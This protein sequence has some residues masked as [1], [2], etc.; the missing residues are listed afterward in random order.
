[1]KNTVTVHYHSQSGHYFDYSFWSWGKFCVGEHSLFSA[2]DSFGLVGQITFESSYFLEYLYVVVKGRNQPL[3]IKPFK[4]QRHK[5]LETTEV[6]IV[7]GD[8][9]LYYS[10]QAAHTSRYYRYR[11]VHAFDMAVNAKRFDNKWGFDGWLG[12]KYHCNE[13]QFRL[14]A[15]TAKKVELLFYE[16]SANDAPL[17]DVIIMNRGQ[18]ENPDNHEENTHGVWFATFFGNYDGQAYTYRL[19]FEDRVVESRDPYSIATTGNGKRSVILSSEKRTPSGFCVKHGKDATWRLDNPNQSV[20]AEMHIRD[21]S[22]SKTSGVSLANRGTYLGACEVETVNDFG[23]KTCFDYLKELEVSHVQ[24]QPIF[25]HHQVIDADGNFAYNWGYDPENYNVPEASFSSQPDKPEVR[26]LELKTMIQ[27]YHNAGIGVIMDVVYNHTY[28]SYDSLFQRI[29]PDYYH[30]MN[31][32]GSFQNGSG[33]GNEMASEKEMYRKYMIDSVLYWVTEYNIDGFRFDLMGLHDVETMNQIRLAVDAID[34][35]IIIYG[36]GWDMGD[37]LKQ[38][39]KA[40]KENACQMPN[41]GFFN[42]NIRDAIK[43]AEVYG[44]IK[45][46]FVSGELTEQIVAKGILGSEGLS[47]YQTP[48]QVLNY[49]E[50][51]DNYNVNDLLRELHPDDDL[52]THTKRIELAIAMSMLMQGMSFI[53]LGQEFLRTKLHPTGEN[54]DLTLTDKALAMNSYN[55]SDKVNQIDWNQVSYHQPTVAFTH[56]LI[57]L[58]RYRPEFSYLS[59]DD[60][61]KH[62]LIRFA[63]TGSHVIVYDIIGEKHYRIIFNFSEEKI[64]H[65]LSDVSKYA[66]VL[67][68]AA[69]SKS[70]FKTLKALSASVFEIK[71]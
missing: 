43:G 47:C 62:V 49:I 42:D 18:V 1:M 33:C 58:K 26:L 45:T 60:I 23:D 19:Y 53:Q 35:R 64:E 16:T 17:K 20:I 13:T 67:T 34:P 8:D 57:E 46:G 21:F 52:D 39:D 22:I 15:P 14:W 37:A 2:F 6:W 12:V 4:I 30:R 11:D 31:L 9:T 41:I 68:N 70:Y 40:I 32:D 10:H 54:G 5:G 63:E 50:A 55:A 3:K 44:H 48:N 69:S 61:R 24:L 27:A 56:S 28:S 29:V 36:E 65:Y 38:E 7:E 25:D 59:F 66:V 71:K 51:H